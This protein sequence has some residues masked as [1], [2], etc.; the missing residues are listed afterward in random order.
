M[1]EVD[2]PDGSVAEFP[3]GTPPDVMKK[4]IQK[5]FPVKQ[6][7]GE[8]MARSAATGLREGVEGIGGMMGDAADLQGAVAAWVSGKLGA[9]PETQDTAR[10]WGSRLSVGGMFPDTGQIREAVTDP[11][12]KATGTED[13]LAHAPQTV[14][15][16]YTRT[17]AQFLPN[18]LAPG[19][20][21]QRLATTF[22]PAIAS[23]TAGQVTKGTDLEPWARMGAAILSGGVS[24]LA[25]APRRAA[26]TIA[27]ATEGATPQQLDQAEQL[28][29][30][31]QAAGVPITRFEAIQQ[32][33]GNA[34]NAGNVQRVI[35]GQGGLRDFMSARPQQ[36]E[37]TAQREIGQIAPP[38]AVP[39]TIGPA[40]SE[41]A[42]GI[43]NDTR[44]AINNVTEPLYTAAS[45]RRVPPAVYRRMQA[46]PG[47]DEARAAVRNDP[48]LARYVQGLP[49][50]SVG[51]MNEVQKYLAQQADNAAGPMNAARNQQRAAGYGV[52]ARTVRGATMAAG[53]RD[54]RTAVR[55]QA[56][57][58]DQ[59]LD[60]LL[61]GH[62]GKLAKEDLTTQQAIDALFPRNPVANSEGEI[63][64][65]VGQLSARRP[66]VAR[67]LVR[68]HIESTFNK[69]TKDL[70]SGANE[71]G[72]ANFIAQLRG[73]RQQAANLEAAVRA[74]P[75]GDALWTGFDRY[76]TI[77]EA[78]GTRQHIGSQTA[79]NQELQQDLRAGGVT[80][81]AVKVAAGGLVRLPKKVMD[82]VERWRLGRNVDQLA[83][84]I[85]NPNSAAQFRRLATATTQNALRHVAQTITLSANAATRHPLEITVGQPA[86]HPLQ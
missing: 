6:G 68:A 42:G 36:V 57:M 33:T 60:P 69:A 80:E 51:F 4:A 39:S 12:V 8:D 85:T 66:A 52:D 79:F 64:T 56:Q 21:P 63:A 61:Q 47:W 65:A 23:E 19:S 13:V 34:T 81:A 53:G 9:S 77:L 7:V 1:I 55:T 72:G 40:V 49:D 74:L 25:T 2:L 67:Q 5:R 73:N 18:L 27:R 48:Q 83:A 30:E 84:L 46:T 11:M 37:A 35:E 70:Q 15:G 17:G 22:V 28:F 59:F 26:G 10:K 3:D 71:F 14:F 50:N 78:Q 44:Q 31:A 58:R 75:N 82:V 16:D 76:L 38:S 29:Q 20:I 86:A 24:S 41:E 62:I 32:V 45:P 54:F 43:I